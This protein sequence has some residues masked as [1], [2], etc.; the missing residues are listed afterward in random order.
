MKWG[1]KADPAKG[2]VSALVTARCKQAKIKYPTRPKTDDTESK[3][4]GPSPMVWAEQA[5]AERIEY[6]Q[7]LRR[8]YR[9]NPEALT[10][11]E[12]ERA[13]VLIERDERKKAKKTEM[14]TS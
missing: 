6:N 5:D 8:R 3:G 4:S 1:V 13:K 11:D 14:E 10:E 2:T 12:K 7:L 9:N